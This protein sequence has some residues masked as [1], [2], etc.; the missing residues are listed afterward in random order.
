MSPY[1]PPHGRLSRR[2]SITSKSIALHLGTLRALG[3]PETNL[4]KT[5]TAVVAVLAIALAGCARTPDNAN[6]QTYPQEAKDNFV[7]ACAAHRAGGDNKQ[8]RDI[9]GCIVTNL[10]D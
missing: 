8:N 4:R 6:T 10:Q 2:G 5:L 3:Y 7:D 9:C 1:L